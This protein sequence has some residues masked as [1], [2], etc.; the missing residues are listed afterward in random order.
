MACPVIDERTDVS[1]PGDPSLFDGDDQQAEHPLAGAL[2]GI[3]RAISDN[4]RAIDELAQTVRHA[5]DLRANPAEP[6]SPADT[7]RP[8]ADAE[9]EGERTDRPDE[10]ADEDAGGTGP[11]EPDTDAD[12]EPAPSGTRPVPAERKPVER[13]AKWTELANFAAA[14]V[15]GP[16]WV[17]IGA[18]RWS[19]EVSSAAEIVRIA[20]AIKHDRSVP[21]IWVLTEVC[22]E[23]GLVA[24]VENLDLTSSQRITAVER[25]LAELPASAEFLAP[26]VKAGW[27]V[28]RN[29]ELEPW[30]HMSGPNNKVVQLVLEP[31][32]W[33]YD[34]RGRG[35][36][37]E[38]G[39][40][41]AEYPNAIDGEPE[42]RADEILRRVRWISDQLGVLPDSNP[43]R[44]V[45]R[46][47]DQDR[48]KRLRAAR[49]E[50]KPKVT[51]D[52]RNLVR[53]TTEA[54]RKPDLDGPAGDSLDELMPELVWSRI[55][56]AEEIDGSEVV[57]EMDQRYSYL[58]TL[59]NCTLGLGEPRWVSAE[60]A[61]WT[62]HEGKPW[63]G[64]VRCQ[65]SA[66]WHEP[67]MFAPHPALSDRRPS[68][69]WAMQPTLDI[70]LEDEDKGGAGWKL[71]DLGITGAYLWPDCG[72]LMEP[73]YKQM[74]P[75]LLEAEQIE[76][77]VLREATLGHLKAGYKSLTGK[78]E[79]QAIVDSGYRTDRY[80]P[81]WRRQV[82]A[83][84]A[85]RLFRQVRRNEQRHRGLWPVFANVDSAW[86]LTTRETAE[87][88]RAETQDAK[89]GQLRP[90]RVREITAEDR[91][92]LHAMSPEDKI[93]SVPY[94][95]S[96]GT[97]EDEGQE[98]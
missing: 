93:I 62:I 56:S 4:T 85:A 29:G 64:A 15:V 74:R 35:V 63:F 95:L 41:R 98:G 1:M 52:G 79:A 96:L 76:D 48:K 91:T 80:Q 89:F 8:E 25:E 82:F 10:T 9:R 43:T 88:L 42:D 38:G 67:R 94:A 49:Q 6:A 65:F 11:E 53:V 18:R 31:Y 44:T 61:I 2:A 72:R 37:A 68:P 75:A 26:A 57:I 60:E 19:F 27:E 30:T 90:K 20:E 22:E 24:G 28:G 39:D 34:F 77:P 71:D 58:A 87:K 69:H 86:Y 46:M 70:V 36:V 13:P 40:H 83:A 33:M 97:D 54:G 45:Q 59:S 51:A 5:L 23:L 47:I 84:T 78:W 14:A 7:E 16:G 55:P 3:E 50:D 12:T 92:S 32:T 81:M 66:P 17:Q 73:F 21:Q